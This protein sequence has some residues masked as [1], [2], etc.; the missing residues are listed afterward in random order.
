[1]K[2][3]ARPVTVV[4]VTKTLPFAA[5]EDA[6]RHG[7]RHIGENRVQEAEGKIEQAKRK[8]L[9]DVVWHMV[10]HVQT[11]KVK[12]VAEYFDWV[13]SVD[14]GALAHSL[15][16]AASVF[17]KTLHALLEVN[18]SGETSKYGFDLGGWERN[19]EKLRKFI[20]EVSVLL[21]M[22]RVRIEGLMTM[23]PQVIRPEDN[24]AMFRSLRLLS[25]TIRVQMPAFGTQLSMGTSQDYQIAIEEGATQV[26]LGAALFG[27]RV[28]NAP[29]KPV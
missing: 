1:M 18:L 16:A 24:R 15:D 10:G 4:A 3:L 20:A 21:P 7:I 12:R 26:R 11:R 23:P 9:D 17:H 22:Q 25:E 5:V 19:R 6:Y 8:N 14:H 28:A 29:V 13:D 2:S 27:Q